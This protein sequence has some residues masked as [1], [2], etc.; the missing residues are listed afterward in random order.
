MTNNNFEL[1]KEETI[2]E[3][4][5]QAKLYRHKATGAQL[6]SMLTDDENKAF[7]IS[8]RTPP[9]D[10]T[11]VPHIMEHSVLCGSRKY[12]LKEPFIE[13]AKGSLNTYLNASTYPDKTC[14]PVASQNL[15]DFYNLVDVY[16]DAVFYPLI[17]SETLKQEGWHYELMQKDEPIKYK[18][19]VFNEMKGAYSSPEAVMYRHIGQL[20]LPDTIY[21]V[22]SGGDPKAIP[23]LTYE[24]FRN[25]YDSYYHPS[26]AFLYFYGDDDPEKRLQIADNYLK[27]YAHREPDSGVTLQPPFEQPREV[28]MSYA[29][30]DEDAAATKSMITINWLL[31]ENNN[32]TLA[33]ALSIMSHAVFRT[34]ASPLRKIL[35][36]SGLGEDVMGGGLSAYMRQMT[37]SAGMKGVKRADVTKVSDL[38]MQTLRQIVAEGLEADMVEAAMNTVEFRMREYNT[39]G[40]PKGLSIM[41]DALS[42]WIHGHDPL[43]QISFERPLAAIKASLAE[44][45]RYFESLVEQYLLQNNHRLTLITEPDAALKNREEAA[46]IAKLAE[47]KA[48]MSEAELERIIEETYHLRESQDAPDDPEVLAL[49]PSLKLSDIDRQSKILPIAVTEHDGAKIL[50]HDLF[51]SG[52][53]YL[54]VGFNLRVIPA[55][56]LPYMSLFSDALLQLGTEK[57]SF[58]K[59]LQRIGRKTGGLRAFPSVSS[60]RHSPESSAWLF[61]RGKCTVPQTDDLLAIMQDILLTVKLD[62]QE[63]FK[64]LVLED[65]A[66]RESSVVPGGHGFVSR[67]LQA[68][69]SEAAW[70]NEQMGGVDYIF[71]LRQLAQEVEQ[72][73]AGVLAKLETIRQLLINRN[74]MICNVTLDETNWQLV[75]PKIEQ[76]MAALP[77]QPYNFATWTPQPGIPF[78]GLTA[79]ASQV[80]YVGK[81]ANLYDLGYQFHGSMSVI[82]NYVRTT[83]LWEKIRVQGGA[84]GAFCNFDR[85]TG[86]FSFGSYRD[87]NLLETLANYDLASEFLRHLNL[88]EDQL[89][90]SI[91]GVIGDIDSYQLADAKG[92]TSMMRYL[93]GTTDEERQQYRAE[94]LATKSYHFQAFAEVLAQFNQQ[95]I[96][97]VLGSPEAI[98]KANAA[99]GGEWLTIT[100]VL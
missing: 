89:T 61:L 53:L 31:P 11:G 86:V 33:L 50:Y 6:L 57:E 38:I 65:K 56:L 48:A 41:F 42:T 12:P 55:D 52:I 1:I 78:E 85:N 64:Q 40:F 29:A 67:R 7:G 66:S 22:D 14:Y 10:S 88:N 87:P 25:F 74:A 17:T 91:I 20:L 5:S 63:R 13:L 79:A 8:F 69:F 39:G 15:Q 2:P 77:T 47:I 54:E 82:T 99:R 23:D 30:S 95:G 44:N 3:L 18:G 72:N 100:K 68:H 73:W 19:V 4:N 35:M 90:K 16:L 96:V 60:Q 46:E 32:P 21:G 45:P 93:H 9:T 36:D 83:Y 58:V 26:N 28:I 51:T 49:V 59:L 76:F 71:F 70:V 84:Y 62:N 37:F 81:A 43:Q 24:Q 80:N 34:P 75:R 27:D 98:N 94:V 97:T 92:Y